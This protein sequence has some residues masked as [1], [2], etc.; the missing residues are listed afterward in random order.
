MSDKQILPTNCSWTVIYPDSWIIGVCIPRVL[1][2]LRSRHL[3]RGRV[4]T[5]RPD[6]GTLPP[7]GFPH[8]GDYMSIL[9][10]D[11]FS[12][13]DTFLL[14]LHLSLSWS[15]SPH[16]LHTFTLKTSVLQ[17]RKAK[18]F[19]Q[20][21]PITLEITFSASQ[22]LPL[23]VFLLSPEAVTCCFSPT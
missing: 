16:P 18:F 6:R 20:F 4:C 17:R 1:S 5:P 7:H 21:L 23:Y 12:L 19:T 11:T 10:L 15:L 13:C 9:K 3:L 2:G 14:P 22:W 8:V